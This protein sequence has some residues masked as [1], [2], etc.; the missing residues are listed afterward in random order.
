MNKQFHSFSPDPDGWRRLDI[1]Y[2]SEG[3]PSTLIF[4]SSELIEFKTAWDWQKEWQKTL[5]EKPWSPQAVWILQHLK[6]YTLG[7]GATQDNLLFNTDKPPFDLYRIDRGGEV[8][9]HLPGQLIAYLVIDLHRYQT[10][11]HWYLR[12]LEQVLLD[13]ID[14]LGLLGERVA[15]RTGIW[16]DGE[17]VASIG[18]GCRR[19]ITKH[20]LSLNVDCDLRGFDQIIPCGLK[21]QKVGRLSSFIPG[22]KTEDVMPL[23]KESLKNH[24]GL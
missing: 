16:I 20:G 7:R 6:C 13:V 23:M 5:L 3:D 11:L 21:G 8:T 2:L 1:D 9:H 17:K 4:Q 24:F 22:I 12:E 15:G 14:K 10:D 18:I 19:W